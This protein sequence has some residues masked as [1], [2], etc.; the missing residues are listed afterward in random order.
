MPIFQKGKLRF[1]LDMDL[2]KEVVDFAQ[3]CPTPRPRLLIPCSLLCVFLRWLAAV[4]PQGI[5]RQEVLWAT[6]P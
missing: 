6:W 3:G 5:P 4:A 1:R 2:V